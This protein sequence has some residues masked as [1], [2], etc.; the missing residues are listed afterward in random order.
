MRRTE[1][2]RKLSVLQGAEQFPGGLKPVKSAM[3]WKLG[4]LIRTTEELLSSS[5]P[6]RLGVSD[7]ANAASRLCVAN[8][9]KCAASA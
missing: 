4:S 6:L 3:W 2:N 9:G 8:R 1:Y 7:A 5:S